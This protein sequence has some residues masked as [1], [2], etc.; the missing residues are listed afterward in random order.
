MILEP[1][2][3]PQNAAVC[4]RK[5]VEDIG[6]QLP[7]FA[8]TKLFITEPTLTAWLDGS[9]AISWQNVAALLNALDISPQTLFDDWSELYEEHL[10]QNTSWRLFKERLSDMDFLAFTLQHQSLIEKLITH[11][12]PTSIPLANQVKGCE[13]E[14]VRLHISDTANFTCTI[15]QSL[16]DAFHVD[17]ARI[18][19]NSGKAILNLLCLGESQIAPL[20]DRTIELA[21]SGGDLAE[22][23]I[24]SE[25]EFSLE[26]VQYDEPRDGLVSSFSVQLLP[27]LSDLL[28]V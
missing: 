9:L 11:S 18:T 27:A 4:V 7:E 16:F 20:S 10:R 15:S 2:T 17:I 3:L 28:T 26:T 5:K 22:V 13:G 23:F 19:V 14:L 21:F 12:H 25:Y 8:R 24:A 6:Y 1:A